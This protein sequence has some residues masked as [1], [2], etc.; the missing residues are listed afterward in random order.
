ML[1]SRLDPVALVQVDA[2]SDD[3]ASVFG[4]LYESDRLM[5]GLEHR[6]HQEVSSS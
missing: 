1:I 6:R 2:G 5:Q 3:S 4:D